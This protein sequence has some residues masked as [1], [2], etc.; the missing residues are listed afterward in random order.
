[1]RSVVSSLRGYVLVGGWPASGK[2]T[3]SRALARELDIAYLSKDQVKEALMDTLG[4][5]ATVPESQRL[6]RAAVAAV[7]S[8][9]RGCPAAVIDSTWFPYALPLVEALDG[10]FVE[11][12][13]QVDLDVARERY[14]SRRRDGRHL[15]DERSEDEL[16]GE[17]VRPLGV[18]PLV[19]VDTTE[20]VDVPAVGTQVRAAFSLSA[21]SRPDAPGTRP[22]R[23]DPIAPA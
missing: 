2:T 12:R 17:P 18:G 11:V 1:M 5:P 21:V 20:P 14:R 22:S 16:W 3:L 6:G 13:C 9:A 8:A 7:M 23:R 10:P 19:L 15:D 4:P